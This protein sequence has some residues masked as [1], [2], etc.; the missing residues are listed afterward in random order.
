MAI[1]GGGVLG[2]GASS[3]TCGCQ[4][5][6]QFFLRCFVSH[7]LVSVLYPSLYFSVMDLLPF[8][9]V[10]GALGFGA[11]CVFSGYV[12]GIP[13]WSQ[14]PML[15][16][17]WCIL[18]VSFGSWGP[19]VDLMSESC[20]L[21]VLFVAGLP[22]IS[23]SPVFFLC[24]VSPD[25]SPPRHRVTLYSLG[26]YYLGALTCVFLFVSSLPCVFFSPLRCCIPWW[27]CPC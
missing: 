21:L 11:S 2:G 8:L 18:D 19:W 7:G 23:F 13:G 1:A 26:P 4:G 25:W 14:W 20:F 27:F 12:L 24:E 17:L 10:F 22:L 5:R 3:A 16:G 15:W 6:V 9:L